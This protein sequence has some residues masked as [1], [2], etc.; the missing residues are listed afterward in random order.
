MHKSLQSN[1]ISHSQCVLALTLDQE[2]IPAT[3][4]VRH[5]SFRTNI[6]FHTLRFMINHYISHFNFWVL[7]PEARLKWSLVLSTLA[8]RFVSHRIIAHLFPGKQLL[9][10]HSYDSWT[11]VNICQI[12]MKWSVIPVEALH[13]VW[14][15]KDHVTG[16]KLFGISECIWM[17]SWTWF[18]DH[19]KKYPKYTKN[20]QKISANNWS[21][22]LTRFYSFIKLFNESVQRGLHLY[23]EVVHELW[24][25]F[26]QI[27]FHRP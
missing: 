14:R 7:T 23:R 2:A 25:T 1:R 24:R 9:I 16:K 19:H 20:T 6:S 11:H 17:H 3:E 21:L 10:I 8:T 27:N 5:N 18:G 15:R 12:L 22:Y 13:S 26:H 4:N